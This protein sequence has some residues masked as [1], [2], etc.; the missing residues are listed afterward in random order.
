[1]F[2]YFT[3]NAILLLLMSACSSITETEPITYIPC[4]NGFSEEY[5]CKNIDLYAILTPEQLLGERVNDIWGWTDPE[6]G[7]EY[8][9]VG[10]TDGV[11]F[12]DISEPSDPVVVGKLN[13]PATASKQKSILAN[14]EDEG[15]KGAS[16][17]RDLK[18]YG[19]H[20]YV[21]SE[22]KNHGLQIFD[23]TALRAVEDPP[24]YF[25]DDARY[26]RFDNAHNLYINSETGFAYVV[27]ITSGDVC[28]DNGGLHIIN[29]QSP[30][31]PE[32]TG[33]YSNE[34]AGGVTRDGYIHDTQCI[35]Y[36]G[37]DEKYRGKEICF[38][39]SETA[40]QIT[41][42]DEKLSPATIALEKFEGSRYIHQ[43]WITEDHNYFFMNDEGDE[44]KFGHNTR[45]YIW[46]LERLESP[47]LTGYF[48]HSTRGVDHNLYIYDGFMHQANYTA[49]LRILDISNPEPSQIIESGYF[50]TTPDND[51]PIFSGLWSVYPWFSEHKIV[52]SDIDNGLFV[53]RFKP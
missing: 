18:V 9:L 25:E 29:I 5:P 15:F 20:L 38:S 44:R 6:T 1:M 2:R 45:T 13:E 47:E 39:S 7:R 52:V 8:A 11:T 42:V 3:V 53:L 48:E 14:H 33:C 43:G 4:E 50:D 22:Q 28:S 30:L 17:W 36:N 16:S 31:Q 24:I 27:G 23:L 12:V 46:N 19:N 41:N 51:E 26:T 34:N 32:F 37:P 35:I 49:G 40:F 10:L 21:V